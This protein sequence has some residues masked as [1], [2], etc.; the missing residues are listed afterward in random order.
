MKRLGE[1]LAAISSWGELH[2]YSETRFNDI[3]CMYSKREDSSIDIEPE[4]VKTSDTV[5]VIWEIE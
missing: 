1:T 2:L 5:T 4:D 3:D